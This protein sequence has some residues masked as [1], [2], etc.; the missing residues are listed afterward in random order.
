MDKIKVLALI[1]LGYLIYK[2]VAAKPAAP[3]RSGAIIPSNVP[4]GAK[5]V[6]SMSDTQVFNR[7]FEVIYEYE[8]KNYGMVVT[9][10]PYPDMYDVVF[11]NDFLN[12]IPG[13]VF[14]VN[15]TDKPM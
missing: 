15:V 9:G 8:N 12:G 6:Y 5:L 11:G 13:R 10:Y 1:A 3:R 4:T 2:K 14:R 7:A